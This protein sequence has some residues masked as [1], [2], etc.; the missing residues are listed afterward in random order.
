MTNEDVSRVALE[1]PEAAEVGSAF[2]VGGKGFAWY[3]QERVPGQKGRVERRDVLAVRTAG[4][5]DKEVLLA[6]MPDTLFTEPHYNGY[7]AVLVRIADI[8]PDAMA[9]LLENAWRTRA[10]RHLLAAEKEKMKDDSTT[11]APPDVPDELT[12]ALDENPA[13]RAR[14]DALAPSHRREWVRFVA[15]AV[16]P[17]TR[18]RRAAKAA[19]TLTA[20]AAA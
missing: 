1:L 14:F 9:G 4:L 15:E 16:K 8:E 7:P 3:W 5:A 11:T 6:A 19:A 2:E 13:A 20:E 18:R 10:P 17:E 12:T